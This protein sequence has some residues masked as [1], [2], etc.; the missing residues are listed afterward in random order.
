[1]NV[2][3]GCGGARR[4]RLTLG[5]QRKGIV[6]AVV[7]GDQRQNRDHTDDGEEVGED[8]AH[9]RNDRDESKDRPEQR[10]IPL[11]L[12]DETIVAGRFAEAAMDVA[13]DVVVQFVLKGSAPGA[14]IAAPLISLFVKRLA[15]LPPPRTALLAPLAIG[16]ATHGTILRAAASTS[17]AV[18]GWRLCRFRV[19][20]REFFADADSD[21]CH[22]LTPCMRPLIGPHSYNHHIVIKGQDLSSN[23]HQTIIY[24]VNQRIG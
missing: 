4:W 8:E 22:V 9:Q 14:P 15:P 7:S 1:M 23:N 11:R 6:A 21:L 16:F 18:A 3:L 5:L 20:G 2:S 19:V 12:H 10:L 24:Y 13:H 17:P